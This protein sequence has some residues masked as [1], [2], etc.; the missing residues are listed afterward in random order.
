MKPKSKDEE[1]IPQSI[2]FNLRQ[3]AI[4][5]YSRRLQHLE[6]VHMQCKKK[7]RMKAQ[8]SVKTLI[9]VQILILKL[10]L[11]FFYSNLSSVE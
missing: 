2:A 5:M 7:I 4:G 3:K 11:D 8:I 6:Q 9:L 10:W 1:V